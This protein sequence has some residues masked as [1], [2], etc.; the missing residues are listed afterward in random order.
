MWPHGRLYAAAAPA[1]KPAKKQRSLAADRSALL[2]C[3]VVQLHPNGSQKPE[4]F[5]CQFSLFS[6]LVHAFGFAL[7][8]SAAPARPRPRK[9]A[10]ICSCV[11]G[12]IVKRSRLFLR[13]PFSS[14]TCCM[15]NCRPPSAIRSASAHI[16]GN[17]ARADGDSGTPEHHRMNHCAFDVHLLQVHHN[18]G[19]RA[20]GRHVSCCQMLQRPAEAHE[21]KFAI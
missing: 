20:K 8:R 21:G 15:Q 11:G 9:P 7:L 12:C 5:S 2:D 4:A 17:G 3:V 16:V 14:C 13:Q 18:R 6:M 1:E 10:A 19:P